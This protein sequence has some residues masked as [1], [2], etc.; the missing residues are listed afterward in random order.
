MNWIVS[1]TLSYSWRDSPKSLVLDQYRYWLVSS[2]YKASA[3]SFRVS[4][5]NELQSSIKV[6]I[7]QVLSEYQDLISG[8]KSIEMNWGFLHLR[9]KPEL[10]WII[11]HM[12]YVSVVWLNSSTAPSNKHSLYWYHKVCLSQKF[13]MWRCMSDNETYFRTKRIFGV[14]K[15]SSWWTLAL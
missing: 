6:P 13:T 4:D 3:L 8:S 12:D 2:S 7:N 11:G 14:L 9:I 10:A 5:S 1:A 15:K